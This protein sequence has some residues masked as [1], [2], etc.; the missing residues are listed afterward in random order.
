MKVQN[1]EINHSTDGLH[2][3]FD[4]DGKRTFQNSRWLTRNNLE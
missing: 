2:K 4:V 3:R 1:G